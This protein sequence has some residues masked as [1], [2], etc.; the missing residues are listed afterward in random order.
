MREF[1]NNFEWE[2]NATDRGSIITQLE[3]VDNKENIPE[4][5]IPQTLGGKP[6][7]EIGDGA[8]FDVLVR[9]SSVIIPE[10]VTRIGAWAF[11]ECRELT[12]VK[13]PEGVT[14][15][16]E[17]AFS[18]CKALANVFVPKSM[19][20][21]GAF[22]FAGC[23]SLVDVT[24][25]DGVDRLGKYAFS[26]CIKL[27]NVVIPDSISEIGEKAFSSCTSLVNISMPGRFKNTC[28]EE[29]GLSGEAITFRE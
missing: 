16:G 23:T 1:N 24:I 5:I 25:P 18:D 6:V 15:I 21:I 7:V 29:Y 8:F 26:G 12:S 13:I 28:L 9:F 4:L 10:G 22:A 17:D 11:S 2:Y 14:E 19:R 3:D 27:S 20:V